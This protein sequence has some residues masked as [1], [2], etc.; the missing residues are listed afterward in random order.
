MAQPPPRA[1]PLTRPASPARPTLRPARPA[2]PASPVSQAA[3]PASL[4]ACPADPACPANLVSPAPPASLAAHPTSPAP[5]ASLAA[6]LVHPPSL[7]LAGSAARH[8]DPLAHFPA[9][10]LTGPPGHLPA[11]QPGVVSRPARTTPGRRRFGRR[12]ECGW[13]RPPGCWPSCR[14]CWASAQPGASSLSAWPH[15]RPGS[16]SVSAMTCRIHRMP[17]KPE[18]SSPTRS[19]YSPGSGSRWS[20]WSA[21]VRGRLSRPSPTRSVPPRER[22]T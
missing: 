10:P 6:H 15:R 22:Q 5:P 3:P 20:S 8:R 1:S 18:R 21:T 4:A 2:C 11:S 7:R 17:R 19:R 12:H 16:S 9:R 13:I 14:T